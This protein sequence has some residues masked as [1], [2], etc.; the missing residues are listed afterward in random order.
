MHGLAAPRPHALRRPTPSRA[1]AAV[2]FDLDDT[3]IVD[4]DAV[5]AALF[6]R[7]VAVAHMAG[8]GLFQAL[9][10]RAHSLWRCPGSIGE[11]GAALGVRPLEALMSETIAGDPAATERYRSAVWRHALT[12]AEVPRASLSA[13]PPQRLRHE[14]MTRYRLYPQVLETLLSLRQR[15]AL[16]LLTNGPGELQREKLDRLGLQDLFHTIVVS[17]EEGIAKPDARIFQRTLDRLGVDPADALMVGNDPVEDV[18]G[19]LDAGMA[20]VLVQHATGTR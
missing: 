17:A 8:E 20:A 18:R 11:R 3:L 9:W 1:P 10:R 16:A 13:E 6:A 5:I 15:H 12:D 2:V 14:A 7:C 19:A 4:D